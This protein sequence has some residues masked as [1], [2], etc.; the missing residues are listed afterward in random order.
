MD[1]L[2]ILRDCLP[3]D[4]VL[5][6]GTSEITSATT[7]QSLGMDSLDFVEYL[8]D[9]EEALDVEIPNSALKGLKTFGDVEAYLASVSRG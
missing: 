8:S 9:V 1:T 6:I 4:I 7:F 2:R 5:R 3:T